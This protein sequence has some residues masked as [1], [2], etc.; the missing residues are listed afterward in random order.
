MGKP[1]FDVVAV[2]LKTKPATIL[3]VM[4]PNDAD[5]AEAVHNMAIMRQGCRDRFFAYAQPGQY[6]EGDKWEGG[7]NLPAQDPEYIHSGG[8]MFPRGKRGL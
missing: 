1:M 4:G 5:N 2:S 3:W 7:V 8:M 6:K